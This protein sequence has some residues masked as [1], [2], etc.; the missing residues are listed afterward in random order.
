[1]KVL[2][3]LTL[4]L[5]SAMSASAQH[6]LAGKARTFRF[7]QESGAHKARLAFRTGA[8]NRSKHRITHS[9]RL[10]LMVLAVD[11]RIALGVDGNVPRTGIRSVEFTFDG[12]KVSVSRSLYA[13]C[14]EP[15]FGKSYFAIKA[16]DDGGSLL[17]FMAGGDAAGGYQVI[18]VLRKDGRHSRF[19]TACSD[20][21]YT[22]FMSFF[23]DQFAR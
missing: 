20:C 6:G 10:D 22:G 9:K 13:D 12:K 2:A 1:M 23:E 5:L 4:L 16:G 18:W 19:S 8:F 11:G 7:V 15:N 17:V 21:D 14:F 3:I